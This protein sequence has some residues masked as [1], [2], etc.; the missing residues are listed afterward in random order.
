[1]DGS[2][3]EELLSALGSALGNSDSEDVDIL[4]CGSMP[5]ILQGMISRR[6]RDVDGVAFVV[7]DADRPVPT[8]PLPAS[9]FRQAVGRVAA[10]HGVQSNWLSFQSRSLLDDGLPDGIAER[11]IVRKYG[12]RLTIRLISRYDIVLLKM[13]AAAARG[14]PDRGDLIEMNTTPEEALAGFEWCLEQGYSRADLLDVLEEIGHAELA[15]RLA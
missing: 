14:E 3:A 15:G 11:A 7:L 1:M 9:S 12:D 2:L 8:K 10:I 13:K 5:M 6:T 4:V